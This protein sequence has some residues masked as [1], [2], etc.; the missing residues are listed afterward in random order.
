[1]MPSSLVVACK[2]ISKSK[3]IYKLVP[4]MYVNGVFLI[5]S[6]KL[7]LK[8]IIMK[9]HNFTF[10]YVLSSKHVSSTFLY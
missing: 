5:E 4:N 7:R 1:M 8:F 6:A 9:T 10:I 2:W 3:V